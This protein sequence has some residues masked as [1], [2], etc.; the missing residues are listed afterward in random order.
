MPQCLQKEARTR[1]AAPQGFGEQEAGA[2][3][4]RGTTGIE[5][6]RRIP[7]NLDNCNMALW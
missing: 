2:A 6:D 4:D 7:E 1:P 5:C 3:E